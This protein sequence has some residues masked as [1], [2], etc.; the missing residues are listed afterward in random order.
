MG[1]WQRRLRR[2]LHGSQ[3]S[4]YICQEIDSLCR[5]KIVIISF[6]C[7]ATVINIRVGLFQTKCKKNIFNLFK[8]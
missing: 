8:T 3:R 2:R 1:R 6:T 7:I 5:L 4:S